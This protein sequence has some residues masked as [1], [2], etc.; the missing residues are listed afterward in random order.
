M[1]WISETCT[2]CKKESYTLAAK[3][4]CPFCDKEF[5]IGRLLNDEIRTFCKGFNEH[6]TSNFIGSST[7][8][9]EE[10]IIKKYIKKYKVKI[11]LEEIKNIQMMRKL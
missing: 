2:N 8:L 3:N 6:P 5:F 11:S 4:K 9:I 7:Q 1:K 10:K